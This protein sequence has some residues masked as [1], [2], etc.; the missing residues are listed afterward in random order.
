[1]KGD[2][3][4]GFELNSES[5]IGYIRLSRRDRL[6]GALLLYVLLVLIIICR[7]LFRVFMKVALP[8]GLPFAGPWGN[9]LESESLLFVHYS[10]NIVLF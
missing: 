7:F 8:F 9:S 4:R 3:L 6:M 10:K 2:V 5:E 1:M